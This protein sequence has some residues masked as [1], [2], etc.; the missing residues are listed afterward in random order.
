MYAV[1]CDECGTLS[2]NFTHNA[3]AKARSDAKR[4]GFRR[5]KRGPYARVDDLCTHCAAQ[6]GKS[7]D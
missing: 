6:E 2:A 4:R 3:S 7:N 1:V 5:V